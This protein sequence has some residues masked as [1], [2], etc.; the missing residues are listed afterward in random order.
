MSVEYS[1]KS[2]SPEKQRSAC[3]VIPIFKGRKLS[4]PAKTLDKISNGSLKRFL[5]RGDIEGEN[6]ESAWIYNLENT[7]C[8][9]VLLMGCGSEREL[10]FKSFKKIC[11]KTAEIL[12]NSGASEAVS[13]LSAIDSGHLDQNTLVRETV[14]SVESALYRFNKY[15]SKPEKVRKPLHKLTIGI[16]RRKDLSSAEQAMLEGKG[17]ATGMKL[18]RDLANSPPNICHPEYLAHTAQ[19]LTKTYRKLDVDILEEK[20]MEALGM[21]ALLSVSQGSEQPAKLICMHYNNTNDENSKPIVLVGKGITFDSGGISIKPSAAMDEMKY[22][23]GGAA[24]V[25][26]TLVACMHMQLPVNIVAVVAAAEN[27]PDGRAS[28]PGDIVT[29]LSEQTVEILNTDAEGRLVLCDA[30]TYIKKFDPELVIDIAT[31]TGACIIALGHHASGML[32]NR[33]SLGRELVQAG[34]T[35]DDR[36]WELPLWDDYAEQLQSNF[37]D[38]ANIGGRPAGTIT[39]AAFLSKFTKDYHWAHLDIAGTAWI[40]GKDKAAT[41]RP[42]PLLTEFILHRMRQT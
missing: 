8:D 12:N 4:R 33:P 3:I 6:G 11:R 5:K 32:T 7:Y 16:T 9:R 40:S 29:T 14:L 10:G 28:R 41:G 27:M 22:D 34:N 19:Q 15:K 26:G 21:G 24:S 39:A 35:I 25:F 20:D 36:L 42:V 38:M 13:Y 37:A 18:A 31:L 1:I 2:G 23:M 30:L 17:I